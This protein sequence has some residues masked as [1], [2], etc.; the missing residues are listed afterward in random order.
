M[1][2]RG[3]R[4][5]AEPARHSSTTLKQCCSAAYDHD[6]VRLLVGDLLHPGGAQLTERLGRILNLGPQT[7]VLDVA[8]GRGASALILAA[9]FGCEVVG[10]DYSWRNVETARLDAGK[11]GLSDR[12]AFYCGDAER[13]PFADG[14][15]D[16]IVCECALCTFPDKQS[17]AAEFAGVLRPGG[18]VGISDLIRRNALPPE[19][20]GLEAWIACVADARPLAEYSALLSGAGL[21]VGVKEEH[22]RALIEFVERIRSRLLA[23]EIMVGLKK[24]ELPGIDLAAVK[25]IARHAL[26]AAKTGK[27]GYAIVTATKDDDRSSQPASDEVRPRP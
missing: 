13:L 6:A 11:S 18:R 15:F 3:R 1:S 4:P 7:R 19:L 5:A 23:T 22:D 20:K 21:N 26:T 10:L 8:T 25:N 12:I 27:L 16:A 24:V 9:R 17:A 2:D 14:A